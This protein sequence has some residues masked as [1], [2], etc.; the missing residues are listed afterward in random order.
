MVA[1]TLDKAVVL[2][3]EVRESVSET[4]KHG[5]IIAQFQVLYNTPAHNPYFTNLMGYSLWWLSIVSKFHRFIKEMHKFLPLS[6]TVL[7][8]SVPALALVCS[9]REIW[10]KTWS[11]SCTRTHTYLC[12][13]LHISIS[14]FWFPDFGNPTYP[15]VAKLNFTFSQSPHRTY[16]PKISPS[17]LTLR[18]PMTD[19]MALTL[20]GTILSACCEHILSFERYYE[21]VPNNVDAVFHSVLH[22]CFGSS[23]TF[24]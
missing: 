5:G 2:E 3:V 6:G 13:Y 17:D 20:Y 18:T 7:A 9:G 12:I 8:W 23:Y 21:F 22:S 11:A 10:C 14:S 4:N 19:F 24:F 15:L 1:W 16:W